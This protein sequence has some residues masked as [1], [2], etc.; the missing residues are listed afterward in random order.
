MVGNRKVGEKR[1]G[2]QALPE[3]S[4]TG[5]FIEKTDRNGKKGERK[6]GR[7]E[8]FKEIASDLVNLD[9]E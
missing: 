2:A 1:D 6:C 4:F 9:G 8:G 7:R 5:F 3:M